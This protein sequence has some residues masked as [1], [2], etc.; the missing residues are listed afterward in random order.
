[1]PVFNDWESVE[2]LLPMIDAALAPTG[3]RVQIILVDDGSLN[4]PPDLGPLAG[5]LVATEDIRIITL[6][7]NQGNQRA[8]AIGVAYVASNVVHDALVV[9]D[10]DLEDKPE[11]I[12]RLLRACIESSSP[13]IVFAQRKKRSEGLRFQTGYRLYKM[14][15]RLLTGSSISMGNFS[16]IPAVLVRRLA[17]IGE[18]WNH[19]PAAIIRARIPYELVPCDRGNRRF[20]R[21]HLNLETFMAHAF[22]AFSIFADVIAVRVLMLCIAA[23]V[24]LALSAIGLTGLRLFTDLAI[25]G[26]TSTIL[27]LLAIFLLQIVTAAGL[28]LF[29]VSLMKLNPRMIPEKIYETYISEIHHVFEN[30]KK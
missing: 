6:S 18:L 15:F 25:L 22:S 17:N 4:A 5:T 19:F 12:P 7:S 10:S 29:L 8:V 24:V 28:M 16:V 13:H 1:M 27:G 21:S 2:C 3:T 30:E 20:G 23:I 9:M 11:D 14:I 26:W